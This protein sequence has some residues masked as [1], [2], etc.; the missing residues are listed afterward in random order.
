MSIGSLVSVLVF[1]MF[2]TANLFT[3]SNQG[4]LFTSCAKQNPLLEWDKLPPPLLHPS[5]PLSLQ[6]IPPPVPQLTF[7]CPSGRSSP[8]QDNWPLR[9][10]ST[11]AEIKG[12]SFGL[13]LCL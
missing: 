7:G 8:S 13:C 5:G 9:T 3:N 4:V 2:N 6:S 12:M 10:N 1:S 11:L